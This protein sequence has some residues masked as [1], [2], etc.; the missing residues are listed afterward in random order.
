MIAEQIKDA[1]TVLF[2]D[3]SAS[4]EETLDQLQDVYQHTEQYIEVLTS[5]LGNK[6]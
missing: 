3:T 5:E 6:S 2:G 4:K 1:I